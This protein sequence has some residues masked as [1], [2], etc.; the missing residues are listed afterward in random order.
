MEDF[1]VNLFILLRISEIAFYEIENNLSIVMLYLI[2]DG[3]SY[4]SLMMTLI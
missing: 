2:L 1:K 4:C 3:K